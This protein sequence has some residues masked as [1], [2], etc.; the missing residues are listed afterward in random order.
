VFEDE[1]ARASITVF[2]A[3]GH[4]VEMVDFPDDTLRDQLAACETWLRRR[5][6]LAVDARSKVRLF[7]SW[8]PADGQRAMTIPPT[9]IDQ[10]AR[11][12]GEY[13]MDVYRGRD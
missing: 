2:D 1:W 5:E 8:A 10:L 11:H 6:P 12:G 7:V 3:V 13:S 9:L 4:V